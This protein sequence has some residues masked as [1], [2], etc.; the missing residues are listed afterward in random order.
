MRLLLPGGLRAETEA[1]GGTF[2]LLTRCWTRGT[3]RHDSHALALATEGLATSIAG[4]TGWSTFGLG[5]SFP[6]RYTAPALELFEELLCEPTFPDGPFEEE[7]SLALQ[8]LLR[9]RES[10]GSVAFR[11]FARLRY[12]PHPWARSP[13]GNEQSLVALSPETLRRCVAQ[14]LRRDEVVLC[15]VGD[16][17]AEAAADQLTRLLERLPEGRGPVQPPPMPEQRT[18]PTYERIALPRAQAHLVAGFDALKVGDPDAAALDLVHAILG[19]QSGRLFR[20][21]RD[22]RGLAYQVG[23]LGASGAD[24][25]W[26]AVHLATDPEQV[27]LARAGVRDEL[28]RLLDDGVEVDELD[29]CRRRLQGAWEIGRQSYGGMSEARVSDAVHGLGWTHSD[30][31][32]DRLDEVDGEDVLRVARRIIDLSRLIEVVVGPP[33]P[34]GDGAT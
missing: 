4:V 9:E 10:P 23:T 25:G 29:R 12:G 27:E 17:H 26:F 21:L 2:G 8:A 28:N 16:V 13:L 1:T 30:G 14:R 22:E 20:A 15:L 7:R 33:E 31:W 5:A 3:R 32:C 18:A 24:P 11:A 34:G 19:G 6:S